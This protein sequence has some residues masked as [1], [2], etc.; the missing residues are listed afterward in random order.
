MKRSIIVTLAAFAAL[1]AAVSC[2]KMDNSEP[3]VSEGPKTYTLSISV[4]K[5]GE[6][7]KAFGSD[8]TV[9]WASGE[10][11]SVYNITKSELLSGY[12]APSSFGDVNTTL[13]GTVT[14]SKGIA[15]ND[16][17]RLVYCGTKAT[18]RQAPAVSALPSPTPLLRATRL[19][20]PSS[21]KWAAA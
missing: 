1:A 16:E 20:R 6:T 19:W 5:D 15:V 10:K 3:T 18:L 17:L 12:L 14:S 11:V 21:L 13:T 7:T 2:N 9:K 4:V 8:Y